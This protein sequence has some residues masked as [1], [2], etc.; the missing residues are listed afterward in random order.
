[1]AEPT[2]KK[3]RVE[4][5]HTRE[6]F[7]KV[8]EVLRD[9]LLNDECLS[10]AND[11]AQAKAA[12]EW[13][14]EVND[15]NVPGGKLNRGMAVYDVLSSIKG[16]EELTEEDIFK[17]N[18][19]GWC[20]EWLQAFFLVADDIMDG[21]ITRRGQPCW[22]KVP[23]VGMIA[24][25]DYILLDC[26]IYRILK[27]HFR[28]HSAYAQLVDLFHEV[29]FQTS[30]GQ[31][32]DLTTAPIG[33]VDLAKYTQDNYLRIVTYKTAYYSFYLPVACGMVLAGIQIQDDYLDCCGDPEVIGKIGTD[34][35]DN[36][37]SWLVCTALQVASDEQ[38]EVIKAHYGRKEADSVAAIKA[39]YGELGMEQRFRDYEAASYAKLD[40]IISEQT[41]LPKEVFS[42]LLAKIYKRK[43]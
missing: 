7:L 31:L 23:K 37:C 30:H 11:S 6:D 32:L 28:S 15:Y 43:K 19:L 27:K 41:L 17:A 40:A 21:S 42:S 26:C 39:L 29:T 20:I 18:A 10:P 33:S 14:K 35:E 1:M 5:T 3:A 36:K 4:Y 13:F 24:C 25:N 12:Q 22:Y 8:Y 38:K 34:I 9:E 2:M 16:V